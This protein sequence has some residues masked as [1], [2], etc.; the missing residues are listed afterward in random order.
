[1]FT[2]LIS[3]LDSCSVFIIAGY[4]FRDERINNLIEEAVIRRQGSLKLIVIDP[5]LFT[6]G[7]LPIEQTLLSIRDEGAAELIRA[8]FGDVLQSGELRT[9][10][11]TLLRRRVHIPEWYQVPQLDP[12][13]TRDDRTVA[14]AF[15]AMAPLYDASQ[16][17]ATEQMGPPLFD[18]VDPIDPGLFPDAL[19]PLVRIAVEL[20]EGWNDIYASMNFGVAVAPSSLA[21]VR[22]P[23]EGERIGK[24]AVDARL[25]TAL[26]AAV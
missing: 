9:T 17:C 7:E 23:Q 12:Q 1:M 25:F 18:Q 24:S 13:P 15:R 6:G 11:K 21:L 14:E 5:A 22:P 8:S 20:L 26:R 3:T 2:R 10:V 19:G 4:S 16:Y